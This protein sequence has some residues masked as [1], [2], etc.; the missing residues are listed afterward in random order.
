MTV[1]FKDVLIIPQKATFEILDK[2]FVFV[3]GQDNIVKQREIVVGA[4]M[5]NLFVVTKGLTE[6]DRIILDGIRMVKE[7]QKIESEFIA[8][9]TVLSKLDLYTE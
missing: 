6:K 3:V 2:K 7:N 5:P 1:P 4:E 8:P 9:K